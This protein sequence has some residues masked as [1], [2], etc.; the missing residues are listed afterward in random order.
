MIFFHSMSWFRDFGIPGRTFCP[1]IR[2]CMGKRLVHIYSFLNKNTPPPC[3]RVMVR[4]PGLNSIT[5]PP[6]GE[7]ECM[8]GSCFERECSLAGTLSFQGIVFYADG[9]FDRKLAV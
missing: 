8:F 6:L 5:I 4:F 1:E 3:F 9:E 7:F 2:L